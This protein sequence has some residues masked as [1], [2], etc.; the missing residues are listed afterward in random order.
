MPKTRCGTRE[1]VMHRALDECPD[2]TEQ[3]ENLP[4]DTVIGHDR[5]TSDVRRAS[6]RDE[7]AEHARSARASEGD[8]AYRSRGGAGYL[9][10][11]RRW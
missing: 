6:Q 5:F 11:K 9:W 2:A 3:H 1:Q 4:N 7:P 10:V 8:S